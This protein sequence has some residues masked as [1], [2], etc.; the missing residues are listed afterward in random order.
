MSANSIIPA[1][2][3]SWILY[4]VSWYETAVETSTYIFDK[5]VFLFDI[6]FSP[7]F[8]VFFKGYVQPLEFRLTQLFATGQAQATL[9][10][11]SE[12]CLF[13][14]YKSGTPFSESC[15]PIL[16][17]HS[18]PILS[19]EIIDSSKSAHYDL[20]DYIEKLKYIGDLD[21]TLSQVVMAWS[22]SSSVLPDP[23]RFSLRYINMDGDSFETGLFDSMPLTKA[24][25]TPSKILLNHVEK[26]IRR[27]SL[28][29]N[30]SASPKTDEETLTER[31]EEAIA[32]T[33][34]TE[35]TS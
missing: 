15:D 1:W 29:E 13:F 11:D 35:L 17:R 33:V 10:Y 28:E 26:S 31:V 12:N 23:E 14:E 34:P 20:S 19:L 25:Q 3:L 22:T 16:K 24:V 32:R 21:L 9:M 5:S 27:D 30:Q 4:G 7:R 8:F 18:L 6:L 2:A